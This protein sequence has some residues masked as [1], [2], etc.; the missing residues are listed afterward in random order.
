MFLKNL[1]NFTATIWL[2]V[3]TKVDLNF[4]NFAWTKVSE[5]RQRFNLWPKSP[6]STK[7]KNWGNIEQSFKVSL[8]QFSKIS[9]SFLV[10]NKIYG[11]KWNF[12]ILN[13]I[14]WY[15]IKFYDN[16]WHCMVILSNFVW[17]CNFLWI[18]FALFIILWQH[19]R[20]F[21]NLE[22]LDSQYKSDGKIQKNNIA[23][24]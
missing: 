22:I 7:H 10:L 16:R 12:T 3:L 8:G 14:L 15:L 4:V 18:A 24:T 2:K 17:I 21:Q 11:I 6:F 20:H 9:Q 19:F 13:K 1:L 23:V 5:I